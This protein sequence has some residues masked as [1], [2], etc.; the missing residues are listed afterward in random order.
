MENV[1]GPDVSLY[2]DDPETPQGIDY[3]KMLVSAG[4]VIVRAGQNLWVDSDFKINWREAKL[5]GLPRGAY[6]FYDSR[7]EPKR[8][9]E[10]WVQQHEGDF[11]ELPLFADLEESYMGPYSGWKNWYTFIERLKQLVSG[12]EIAIYTAYY[13]WRD[14]APN[15]TTQASNLE[16]FHQYPLW[17]AHYGVVE[18]LIPLPWKKGEWLFWQ[19][20]EAGDGKLYGTESNGVDLNYF[21]GDLAA[22][23][24]RF[25][26]VDAPPPPPGGPPPN[27]PLPGMPPPPGPL[28]EEFRLRPS[29]V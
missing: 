5:A 18:P 22:L 21:N 16:Y 7:A 29:M 14:N 10:L 20:T 13:Y 1:I 25:N 19:Y 23:K 11:G 15:A 26:L 24:T 6:W 2:E 3:V 8:Q 28:T 12:K 17:I 27:P 9:A 4:Y